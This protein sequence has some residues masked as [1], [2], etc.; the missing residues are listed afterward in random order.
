MYLRQ[1]ENTQNNRYWESL[2]THRTT[3]LLNMLY[4]IVGLN[5]LV[6]ND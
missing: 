6:K 4:C 5:N 3:R 1:N 2:Q